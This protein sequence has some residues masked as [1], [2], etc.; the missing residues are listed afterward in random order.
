MA[1]ASG[2][3]HISEEDQEQVTT[4]PWSGKMVDHRYVD[5]ATELEMERLLNHLAATGQCP[6]YNCNFF[7]R[8]YARQM[9]H[10][11][12][13]RVLFIC[14]C[15]YFSSYRDTT[16]KHAR[17]LHR[18]ARSPV[19][20]V[21]RRNWAL[22]RGI[23]MGLPLK[24]PELPVKG[25]T[26]PLKNCRSESEGSCSAWRRVRS[27]LHRVRAS[28]RRMHS[29]L[30]RDRYPLRREVRVAANRSYTRRSQPVGSVEGPSSPKVEETLLTTKIDAKVQR[31]E[32]ELRVDRNRRR[33]SQL[34]K[35]IEGLEADVS[36]LNKL[37]EGLKE[38]VSQD[39][40][41]LRSQDDL[42]E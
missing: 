30:Q 38:D 39:E 2:E 25:G 35:L 14:N 27:P 4:V 20:Q 28:T 8:T 16:T 18:A 6:E 21:D 29:P 31:T 10:A 40:L 3:S 5:G 11:E 32:V 26:N 34:N 13:H 42:L 7:T 24:M 23:V 17:T 37:I 22:A 15:G 9:H 1:K 33:I 36:Q 19:V 12:S 41:W